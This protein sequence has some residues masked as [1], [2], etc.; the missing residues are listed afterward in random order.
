M[1]NPDGTW[2]PEAWHESPMQM[3]EEARAMNEA[4]FAQS[5]AM[6]GHFSNPPAPPSWMRPY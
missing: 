1:I 4:D 6:G 5:A 2:S 3:Q